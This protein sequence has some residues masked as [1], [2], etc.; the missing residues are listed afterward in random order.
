M[1]KTALFLHFFIP[2]Q[3]RLLRNTT[4]QP[5]YVILLKNSFKNQ[6]CILKIIFIW[7]NSFYRKHRKSPFSDW[8]PVIF[9]T[10]HHAQFKIGLMKRE[11]F[12]FFE[13][14]FILMTQN[15]TFWDIKDKIVFYQ[16]TE[17]Y[18]TYGIPCILTQWA[19]FRCFL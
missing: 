8:I 13:D 14:I 10:V 12:R 6:L 3:K 19:K 17:T 16:K 11:N 18:G 1:R 4:L 5:F 9:K 7:I 2:E 15:K